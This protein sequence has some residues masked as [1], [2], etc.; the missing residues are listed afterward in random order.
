MGK[1]SGFLSLAGL[2]VLILLQSM[3]MGQTFSSIDSLHIKLETARQDTAKVNILIAL[4]QQYVRSDLSLSLQYVNRA[5]ELAENTKDDKL[6]ARSL[7]ELGNVYFLQGFFE[8]A[9]KTFHRY[10]LIQRKLG[11]PLGEANALVSLGAVKLQLTEFEQAKE[12]FYKAL[13]LYLQWSEQK[14]D[15]LPPRQL[16]VLYNNL[17][18]AYQN[19]GE[20]FQAI[21]VYQRGIS[22]ARLFKEDQLSNL[23]NLFN[24]LGSNYM[25]MA[26]FD[27][28]Y[29][30]ISEALRIRMESGDRAGQ[31]ASYRMLGLYFFKTGDFDKSRDSFYRTL[32][33]AGEVGSTSLR[34]AS[35]E[36]LYKIFKQ[37]NQPD[38]ALRYLE[39]FK[40]YSD[41]INSEETLKELSRMEL[42][43]QMEERENSRLMQQ[44]RREARFTL[45]TV[46]LGLIM[47][48][49]GLLYTLS[50]NRMQRL[51]LENKNMQLAAE[52]M[53]L[54]NEGLEKELE[55]KNKELTTNVM[56]QIR[57]NEFIN[58]IA[59][60]LLQYSHQMRRENQQQVLEIVSEL[61]RSQHDNAWEEFE[62]RFHQV[63]NAFFERLNEINPELSVNERRLCAFLRLNMTTKEIA[64]ITGQSLRSIEVART[65][66][67]KKLDLTNSDTGLIEFLTSL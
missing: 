67:R 3:A 55:L 64:S 23:G 58:D 63:H 19:L 37:N 31:A 47:I 65:R 28:A 43:A 60:K 57:K 7:I 20:N 5:V 52:N 59:Q 26:R 13:E 6:I 11:D 4:A 45:T 50:R 39:L 34:G 40:E 49:M 24:N 18:I 66:L 29:Q 16:V 46:A 56:Y 22:I 35:H 9:A 62:V 17:G 30:A 1:R 33:L 38:S 25:D 48:I 8:L 41:R 12:S 54:E 44:K 10:S 2:I 36:Y 51:G 14:G 42:M 53:Q 21:D 32:L 61:E 15:T 27:D